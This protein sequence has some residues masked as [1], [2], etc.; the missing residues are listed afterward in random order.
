MSLTKQIDRIKSLAKVD[1]AMAQREADI[2]IRSQ[3]SAGAI[4]RVKAACR[5]L[6]LTDTISFL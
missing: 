1:K 4:T 3:R 5:A 6:G 2:A